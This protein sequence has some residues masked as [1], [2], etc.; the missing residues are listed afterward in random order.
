MILAECHKGNQVQFLVTP[1]AGLKVVQRLRS[2]LT[3]SRNRNRLAGRRISQFTLRHS[4]YPYH[5]LDG[6]RHDCVLIWIERE[7]R[8]RRHE[9][10]D[11][12]LLRK[13]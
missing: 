6:S 11:D 9:L 8:H 12:F 7:L 13:L 10:V 1:G 4:V 2:A 5:T 3:R